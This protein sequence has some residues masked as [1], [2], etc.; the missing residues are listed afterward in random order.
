MELRPIFDAAMKLADYATW[1]R[2]L[3]IV[4]FELPS[5]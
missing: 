5:Q 1:R 3:E 4:F 2:L